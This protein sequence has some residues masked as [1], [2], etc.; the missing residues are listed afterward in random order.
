MYFLFIKTAIV[1]IKST[2]VPLYTLHNCIV[3]AWIARALQKVMQT[4]HA[5]ADAWADLATA[6]ERQ[7]TKGKRAE[8]TNIKY[9][10]RCQF[11]ALPLVKPVVWFALA[12]LNSDV[13]V[14]LLNQPNLLR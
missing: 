8:R 13:P 5:W 2:V 9:D 12:V 11:S 14:L 7:L 1:I 3:I 10:F 4:R 6:R